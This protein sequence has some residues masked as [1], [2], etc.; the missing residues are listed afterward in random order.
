MERRLSTYSSLRR[1]VSAIRARVGEN[2]FPVD[3]QE[4]RMASKLKPIIFIGLAGG[5]VAALRKRSDQAKEL[6]GRAMDA[7]PAPVKQA[8]DKIA[9]GEDEGAAREKKR[10]FAAPAEAGAQPPAEAGGAPSDEPQPAVAESTASGT[11]DDLADAPTRAH[12]LPADVVMPD[13]SNDDPAVREAEAAAAA[14]AGSIG[15]RARKRGKQP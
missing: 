5:V 15:G 2:D 9:G 12:D 3:P 1:P 13:T 11:G 6:A 8:V 14:D 4:H 7:A 10:R